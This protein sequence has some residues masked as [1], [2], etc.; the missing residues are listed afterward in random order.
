[1]SEALPAGKP[2]TIRTGRVG[3]AS[4]KATHGIAGNAAV[5]AAKPRNF[6]RESFKLLLR[7][8]AEVM[9]QAGVELGLAADMRRELGAAFRIGIE[10]K[11]NELRLDLRRQHGA[12]E[13]VDQL[14]R[15]ILGC[16][17]RR[18]HAE[19]DV[20]LETRKTGCRDR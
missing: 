10:R 9:D 2:A 19:P 17:R 20:G 11:G 3:Y 12:P 1:M 18:N 15:D 14:C 13:P 16:L 6:R 7:L 5:P 4:D 8:D